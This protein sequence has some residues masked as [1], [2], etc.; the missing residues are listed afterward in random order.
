MVGLKIDL[1]IQRRRVRI[2]NMKAQRMRK[3][4]VNVTAAVMDVTVRVMAWR[5]SM[6]DVRAWVMNV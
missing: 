6:M 5:V 4:E 3:V 2:A 1:L